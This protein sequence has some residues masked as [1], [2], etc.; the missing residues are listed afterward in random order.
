MTQAFADADLKLQESHCALH[1]P[2]G[3]G[4][5]ASANMALAIL[6]CDFAQKKLALLHEEFSHDPNYSSLV[7]SCEDSLESA[8]DA[9]VSAKAAAFDNVCD[10][11]GKREREEFDGADTLAGDEHGLT[12]SKKAK[13]ASEFKKRDVVQITTG[14]F[15]G[16][17]GTIIGIDNMNFEE[18]PAAILKT[19]HTIIVVEEFESNVQLVSRPEP[20]HG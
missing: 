12:Q 14:K 10:K 9:V 15:K 20:V 6:E 18:P 8:K 16:M 5:F 11:L 13:Q 7:T 1:L 4:G 17:V 3:V 2:E 19:L